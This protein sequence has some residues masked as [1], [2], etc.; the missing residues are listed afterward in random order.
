MPVMTVQMPMRQPNQ[1]YNEAG[2]SQDGVRCQERNFHGT[3]Q[4]GDHDGDDRHRNDQ[5]RQVRSTGV[6]VMVNVPPVPVMMMVSPGVA[7]FAIRIFIQR[8]FIADADIDFAHSFFS[9][10]HGPV[11]RSLKIINISSKVNITHQI[12]IISI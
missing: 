11:G 8:K 4:D 3:G 12:I 2:H 10:K 9:L 5:Q 7:V 6:A 1:Q